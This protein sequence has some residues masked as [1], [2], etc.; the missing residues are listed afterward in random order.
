[1]DTE[2]ELTKIFADPMEFLK[3]VRI[4]EPGELALKYELWPHLVK[5]YRDLE[6]LKLII[7]D[8]SKQIGISWAIAARALWKIYTI[9][10]FNIL[11]FSSGQTEAQKLLSKSKIIYHNLPD[12]MKVKIIEP[13]SS[14]QF[15]FGK[16]RSV[17]RALPSTEKAGIGETAGWVIHDEAEFHDF[18]EVN[19]GHTL[20]TVADDPSR[21]LTIVST[22]DKTKPDSY[23]K[24]LYKGAEGSGFPEAGSN[25]FHALFFP[26]NVRPNRDEAFLEEQRRINE[27]TPW[28]V[29]ANYPRTVQE[30]L[31]PLSAQSCFNKERLDKLWELSIEPEIRQGFIY[32]LCPPRVGTQYVAGVDVGEGVGLDYSCLSIIGKQGLS[33]EVVAVIYTNTLATDLFAYEI[34]ELCKSYYKPLLAI[35]N[36]SLGVAVTNKV[37]ELGYTNLF[38]SEAEEKRKRNIPITGK[39]K[40][41]WTTGEKNKQLA[42]I[43]L[44]SSIDNGSLITRFKPQIKELMEQQWAQGKPVPTGKTHGDTVISLMIANAML[45]KIGS[46][47]KASMYIRGRQVF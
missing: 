9:P 37:V 32:I 1:M 12:W 10:A 25:S 18:F 39:E 28:V 47:T 33:S 41:G 23:F 14:E 17:I 45:K 5:F 20:A 15:G 44:V 6:F 24:R 7:L 38:S 36:N 40:V 35:E 19:L 42:L 22:V 27:A 43:E 11:E 29:E 8:K 46:P 16:M 34:V 13:D 4:Q 31:S 21:Q 30:S 26:Y 3:Y 2:R